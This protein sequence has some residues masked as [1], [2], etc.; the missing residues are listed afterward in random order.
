LAENRITKG[1]LKM[2]VVTPEREEEILREHRQGV[3]GTLLEDLDSAYTADIA[4]CEKCY[5]EFIKMWPLAK[6]ELD[7][8]AVDL[9]KFYDIGT[10]LSHSLTE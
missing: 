9:K 4:C 1:E 8:S 5:D 2:S 3:M 7:Q 6:T 10:L